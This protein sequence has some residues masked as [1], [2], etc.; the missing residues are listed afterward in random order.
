MTQQPDDTTVPEVVPKSKS[1]AGKGAACFLVISG[2]AIGKMFRLS[3]PEMLLGRGDDA[4]IIID[5]DAISR[6]HARV[7][8]MAD[9][10][11]WIEDLGSK[12]G[13][14][15]EGEKVT[16]VEL[17]DGDRVLVGSSTILKLTYQDQIEEEFQKQL[18]AS[19]TRDDLTGLLNKKFLLERFSVEFAYC[20]RHKVPLSLCMFDIDHFKQINDRWGHVAGDTV[21]SQLGKLVRRTTR[22]EDAVCRYGGEEFA[23]LLREID[24]GNAQLF[25]ERIRSR[26][27][28]A[29]FTFKDGD[30]R[31][32]TIRLT[33]SVGVAT[34]CETAQY[35]TVEELI[36]AADKQL[37]VAKQAGRNRVASAS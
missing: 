1:G 37:Y 12:N 35:A 21:L 19:A 16:R 20:K 36:T 4:D 30:G 33:I 3:K 2:K 28:R 10:T 29:D 11:V 8:T 22:P 15:L 9:D 26:V 6:R 7:E 31:V 27:E 32:Q 14:Y 17:H 25:A 5:D 13:T 23:V 34:L 18:Y 24:I